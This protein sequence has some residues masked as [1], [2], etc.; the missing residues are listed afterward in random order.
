[1]K[2]ELSYFRNPPFRKVLRVALA[3]AKKTA[4][5]APP[6]GLER[7]GAGSYSTEPK[8]LKAKKV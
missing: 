7:R 2:L 3:G 4:G 6:R 5:L 8:P 1:M